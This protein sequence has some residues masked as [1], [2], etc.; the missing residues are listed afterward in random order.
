MAEKE[1]KKNEGRRMKVKKMKKERNCL[2]PSRSLLNLSTRLLPF[3]AK[4]YPY[5]ASVPTCPSSFWGCFWGRTRSILGTGFG[6]KKTYPCVI[7]VYY[8]SYFVLKFIPRKLLICQSVTT[9]IGC[10]SRF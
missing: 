7:A 10:I 4:A 9:N 8:L 1:K 3:T 5:Q 2:G 6:P